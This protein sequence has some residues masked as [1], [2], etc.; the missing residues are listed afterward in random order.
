MLSGASISLAQ[1][2]TIAF[3]DSEV[4]KIQQQAV[5]PVC[6]VLHCLA[7]SVSVLSVGGEAVSR[8]QMMLF[9]LPL[10]S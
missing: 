8:Q 9:V 6:R 10:S 1:C 3:V 4:E 5:I 2:F 7:P